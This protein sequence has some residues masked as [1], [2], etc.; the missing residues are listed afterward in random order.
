MGRVV[1]IIVALAG[2]GSIATFLGVR[3]AVRRTV[4]SLGREPKP[5]PPTDVS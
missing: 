1:E 5:T 4:R 3:A 2:I